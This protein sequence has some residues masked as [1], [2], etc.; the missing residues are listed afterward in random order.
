[1]ILFL[2]VG[3]RLIQRILHLS[4]YFLPFHEP[5]VL[6]SENPLEEL[7][8]LLTQRNTKKIFIVSDPVVS[9]LPYFQRLLASIQTDFEISIF[10]QVIPNPSIQRIEMA[11]LQYKAFQPDVLIAIGGG[12]SIDL[13]KGIGVRATRPRKTLQSRKGILRVLVRQ[14]FMIAIPTTAGTGSEATVACVVTD[15][16][17][18]EKYAIND[19]VLIPKIA[20]L[21]P[22]ALVGLPPMVTATT[23]MDALTHAI[24][25]YIGHSN[26]R[27][28][29]RMAKEAV[30]LIYSHLYSSFED[31]ANLEHRQAM[32]RASYQAGVAFTRAYVGNVHALAHQLGG[33]FQVPHGLAN[34]VLL[35]H[36]LRYYGKSVVSRLS[37]L[38]VTIEPASIS[39]DAEA[40]SLAMIEW[41]ESLNRKMGI[42][43]KLA[44]DA[45]EDQIR[46]MSKRAFHEANPLYPVPVI[47][48]EVDFMNL[49]HQILS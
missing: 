49:Y 35:P 31:G 24:E 41:I 15:E 47:F 46:L 40:R 12:S 25:A 1:M 48:D 14:P 38:F 16:T 22:H 3:T 30:S 4:M 37:T 21:D 13:A 19:P 34:A 42:P 11:Y 23:G 45:Q 29:K 28:T 26:T 33:M 36:V 10:N 27:K 5:K 9:K 20:L 44:L 32:L 8:Q 7:H 43:T 6:H 2:R 39:L 17:T 18:H